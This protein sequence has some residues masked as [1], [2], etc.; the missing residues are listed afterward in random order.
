MVPLN[1]WQ[2]FRQP[3]PLILQAFYDLTDKNEDFW[4][5]ACP[6]FERRQYAAGT[7]VF[8]RGDPPDGFY[9]LEDG[10]FRAEYHE[11][12]GTFYESI[13]AGTTCGE[14]PLFSGT[15]R[16]ATLVTERDSVAWCLV[17]DQWEELQRNQPDVAQE[18]LKVSLKLTSE[19]MTAITSSVF[20][21]FVFV[22]FLPLLALWIC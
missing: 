4:F 19:R 22:S 16:T 21:V 7:V 11:P 20:R 9:L 5:R 1:K 6:F 14:L 2:H 12:Q 17:P 15:G 8:H 10:I 18:L 13:V 3:L